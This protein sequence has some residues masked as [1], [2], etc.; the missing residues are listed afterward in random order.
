MT[1]NEIKQRVYDILCLDFDEA[2]RLGYTNKIPRAVNEATFRIANAVVP[3]LREYTIKISR[4]NFPARVTMPPDFISFA[5]EQDAYLNGKNFVLTNF[6]GDN[7]LILYGNE[8]DDTGRYCK[9]RHIDDVVEYRIFYNAYYPKVMDGGKYY[10]CYEF[11]DPVPTDADAWKDTLIPTE[12][13]RTTGKAS[14]EVP[15][16]IGDL[17][18]HYVVAQLLAFDDKV[19]SVQEMNE[20]EVLLANLDVSRHER[21]RNYHSIRG[22]Y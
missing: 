13:D 6:I 5:T 17:I 20:F 9:F 11:I 21:Q 2:D 7:G 3:Y 19:R 14:F 18:P 10:L 4:K 1:Y 15:T 16:H 12:A 22:W 8:T